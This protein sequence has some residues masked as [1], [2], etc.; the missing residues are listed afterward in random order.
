MGSNFCGRN[1]VIR[2][3]TCFKLMDACNPG[4]QIS[5]EGEG[6]F[7]FEEDNDEKALKKAKEVIKKLL[8]SNYT[9]KECGKCW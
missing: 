9:V 1:R 5:G 2:S 7:L 8:G 6:L 3:G 4:N